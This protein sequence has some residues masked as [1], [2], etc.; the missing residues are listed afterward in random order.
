MTTR[1]ELL[2]LFKKNSNNE[3]LRSCD[4]LTEVL[5]TAF[6]D[7]KIAASMTLGHTEAGYLIT[8]A[9]G[10]HFRKQLLSDIKENLYYS[11]SFDETTN[12]AKEKE[13]QICVRYYS[14]TQKQVII[15]LIRYTFAF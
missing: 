8:D 14:D 13:L 7:S 9:L 6:P 12:S 3:S 11:I 4:N 1:A 5:K 15:N 2:I 10:P